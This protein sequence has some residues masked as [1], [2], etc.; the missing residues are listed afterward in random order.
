MHEKE[1]NFRDMKTVAETLKAMAHP[2]RLGLLDLLCREGNNGLTV[3]AACEQLGLQQ[4][5]VSRHLIIL[6][7]A[8]LVRR[9]QEGSKVTYYLR[10]HKLNAGKLLSC[11]TDMV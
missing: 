1:T 7:N 4:P 8:G 3:K 10:E 5:I 2:D 11:F 9:W 6:K